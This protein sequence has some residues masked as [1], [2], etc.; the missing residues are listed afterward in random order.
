ME[1]ST[2]R[3]E[4]RFAH[5]VGAF[6]S[7]ELPRTMWTHGAHVAIAALYLQRHGDGVL[8]VT[9]AAIRRHNRSVGTPEGAYHETLTIFWLAAVDDFLRGVG[10]GSEGSELEVVRLAVVEFGERRKLHAEYYSFDV[11]ASAEARAG[12]VEPD[13]RPLKIRFILTPY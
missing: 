9:R 2:L 10:L 3:D 1:I 5:F 8:A 11:V 4:A 7:G 13:V 6:E 12:W